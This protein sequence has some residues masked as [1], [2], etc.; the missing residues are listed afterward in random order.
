[1]TSCQKALQLWS[2]KNGGANAEEA[3]EVA[4]LCLTPPITKMDSS[5]NALVN[6][7]KLS[8]STNSIDKMIALPGLRQLEILSLGRNQIKKI[9]GL[10]EVGL[11]LKELW[12]SYNH[13]TSLDGLHPCVKLTT[14]FI[15]NNK[16]K[17]WDELHKLTQLTE[18]H[19]ILLWG[20]PMYESMTK[21]AGSATGPEIPPKCE[22]GRWRAP[23]R[24]KRR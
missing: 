7:K 19:N 17:A 24:R 8:L 16:I 6:C 23:H 20:N 1:M 14:L 15:S 9:Q 10:E 4:L 18:L 3:T 13:I 5:L 11:T 21:K 22:D 2:E 12:I